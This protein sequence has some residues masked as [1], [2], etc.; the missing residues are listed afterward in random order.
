MACAEC[1][2]NNASCIMHNHQQLQ[3]LLYLFIFD[4][5][6]VEI[7]QSLAFAIVL[8]NWC[9]TAQFIGPL[10]HN[11]MLI[12]PSENVRSNNQYI[13]INN[14]HL[15]RR[16]RPYPYS[17]NGECIKKQNF[18]FQ[19]IWGGKTNER[20]AKYAYDYNFFYFFFYFSSQNERIV[21]KHWGAKWKQWRC[22]ALATVDRMSCVKHLNKQT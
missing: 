21:N 14:K 17:M 10:N 5:E 6:S 3:H 8:A 12:C 16:C 22:R 15:V 9:I 7:R 4:F 13:S 11:N 20:S 1:K 18:N 2:Y 19:P